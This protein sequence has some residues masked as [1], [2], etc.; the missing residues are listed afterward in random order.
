MRPALIGSLLLA[1]CGGAGDAAPVRDA[2]ELE[3]ALAS[4]EAGDVIELVAGVYE[5]SFAVP[6]GVTVRG[7]GLDATR[8][9][10]PTD[11]VAISMAGGPSPTRLSGVSVHADGHFAVVVRGGRAVIADA[12][13]EVAVRGAGIGAEGVEALELSG[14]RIAGHVTPASAAMLPPE[15]TTDTAATHGLVVID[16]D[17]TLSSVDVRGFAV[18]GVLLRASTFGFRGGRVEDCAGVSVYVSGGDGD[19]DGVTVQ[20][21][22]QGTALIPS[23]G[24]VAADGAALRTRDLVVSDGEGVGVFQSEASAD[25]VD[26]TAARNR[27]PGLWAQ[28]SPRLSVVGGELNGNRLAGIVVARSSDVTLDDLRV[29]DTGLGV[30]AVGAS[31]VEFGDGV[32]LREATESIAI[33]GVTLTRNARVGLLVEMNG[34]SGAGIDV[35]AVVI[36]GEAE[37][38]GAVAQNG[39]APNGWE[40]IERR[41]AV[42]GNDAVFEG[43]LDTFEI[44]APTD[45]RATEGIERDGLA[46]IV[47]P[48][49]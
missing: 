24:V 33:R 27:L 32:Q 38:L 5:G 14:V 1:A 19:L 4:A 10:A 17:V 34:G 23:Y 49:D 47:A 25:H 18:A 48:T 9:V 6:P 2:L 40:T 36:D 35:A 22:L 26:L 11:L 12:A 13:V 15:P 20:G 30:R 28:S 44:V 3:Q 7:Q 29:S 37:Q 21:A 16:S 41:G 31:P 39:D 46:G 42:A 45:Y 43:E 8:I